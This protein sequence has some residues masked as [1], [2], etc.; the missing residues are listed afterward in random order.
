VA[1]LWRSR[2]AWRVAR[3]CCQLLPTSPPTRP[4]KIAAAAAAKTLTNDTS[5]PSSIH[6]LSLACLESWHRAASNEPSSSSSCFGPI[7]PRGGNV[8]NT[9]NIG[10]AR[11]LANYL[12]RCVAFKSAVLFFLRS[13]TCL[14]ALPKKSAPRSIVFSLRFARAHA[15]L[16]C[17]SALPCSGRRCVAPVC[18]C[19]SRVSWRSASCPSVTCVGK[20]PGCVFGGLSANPR[21]R[22]KMLSSCAV[23]HM[24]V[25]H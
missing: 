11:Y 10:E 16:S 13:R 18:K 19:F 12:L 15:S 6:E 3:A 20:T 8:E 23:H 21:R 25:R 5:A 9:A 22:S 2:R 17:E 14:V 24:V 4:I 7:V 1:P